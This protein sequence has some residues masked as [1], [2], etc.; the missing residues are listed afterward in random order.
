M[1]LTKRTSFKQHLLLSSLLF[2]LFLEQEFNFPN[3][4]RANVGANW[5]QLHW[6]L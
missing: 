4:L 3:S 6:V 1:N 5:S 2:G